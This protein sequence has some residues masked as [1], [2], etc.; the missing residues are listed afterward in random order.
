MTDIADRVAVV[1]GGASGI[2]RGIAEVLIEQ[3]AHLVIADIDAATL[4]TT[5][6]EIGAHA[7]RT[8]VTSAP[9]V[10]ALADT[11]LS[12]FGRVDIVVNNAG[13]GP[14]GKVEDLTLDDW[15]WMLGV[16]LWG[17]I[18][19][20]HAFLPHLIA[21]PDGGHVVNTASMA[22]FNPLPGLGAYTA[23][24]MGVQ[25]LS[26]VLALELAA[27]HPN[28]HVSILP[29]GPVH[30][31]IARSLRHRPAGQN[32]TLADTDLEDGENAASLRWIEP[33]RAG[34]IVARAI[35]NNDLYAITHP[36]WW[37]RVN[38]RVEMIHREFGRYLAD[39]K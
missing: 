25:G 5:A 38:E 19:G 29:P 8:D 20:I 17:V 18:H 15:Q 1:T 10:A 11:T 6:A 36:D 28:V 39:A 27:E 3:G 14:A 7:V 33:R 22:V 37:P 24:K 16:N 2:G 32:G 30:T 13:I 35:R 23:A 4:A 34:E 26:E 9:S 12:V 31:N 21:N